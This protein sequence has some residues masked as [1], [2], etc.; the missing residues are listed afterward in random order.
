MSESD[1][2]TRSETRDVEAELNYIA[3]GI[4]RPRSYTF[5]PPNGE[6][7]TNVV[8]ES[9]RVTIRPPV[10]GWRTAARGA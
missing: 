7:T 8:N 2:L 3:A 6:P 4:D 5:P 9:H 1:V 10:M